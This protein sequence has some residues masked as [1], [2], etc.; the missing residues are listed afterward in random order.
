MYKLYQIKKRLNFHHAEL[1]LVGPLHVMGMNSIEGILGAY[2]VAL[3]T[4][5]KNMTYEIWHSDAISN[6]DDNYELHAVGSIEECN[7]KIY[8]LIKFIK[9]WRNKMR[10]SE[11]IN[12]LATALSK[13]QGTMKPAVFNK[14]NPHYK[15][16]YADFSSCMDACRGPLSANGLAIIQ[17]CETT[18]GKLNLIT[19]LAHTSGQWIKSEFPLISAK[20]DS[21][22]I[23][24][25]M[26]YA[27]RYSLCG[28]VGIVAD[29]D[30]D[31]DGEAA[32]GRGKIRF[33]EHKSVYENYQPPTPKPAVI[34]KVS[35]SDII[36]LSALIHQLDDESK[37]AFLEWINKS[38]N[39]AT[40]QE[41][42]KA[43]FTK[44][45]TSLS[46]KIKMLKD[47]DE[48]E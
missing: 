17:Y 2:E 15:N 26:T 13:A 31:D 43:A 10:Q 25:A 18:D 44:C 46:A 22:G 14:K 16:E 5:N 36:A 8:E 47:K 23:G 12:E 9:D 4:E 37:K 30:A 27:K 3:I 48:T 40:L 24:S 20:M 7:E 21:Q 38:F 11:S 19:M 32:V 35:D 45:M 28:M 41:I 33:E 39:A 42:P 6:M 34:E 1:I 29:A